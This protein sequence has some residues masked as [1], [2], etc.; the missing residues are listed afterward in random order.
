VR[1]PRGR[2]RSIEAVI[3]TGYN[4]WLTFP[5]RLIAALG[6]PWH[7]FG[8]ATL[9]DGSETSFN[10][11]KG[12]IIWDRRVRTIIIG[13]ADAD[14][15]LG[16]ALLRGYELNMKVQSGGKVTIKRMK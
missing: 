4:G 16:M 12:A 1:G 15:L 9:A 6:L 3:D 11:Y 10:V 8:R 14:P 7:S 5:P 2:E 13:E